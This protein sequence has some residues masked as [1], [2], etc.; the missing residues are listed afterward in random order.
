MPTP[1]AAYWSDALG[2]T[3]GQASLDGPDI[4]LGVNQSLIPGCNFPYGITT[5]SQHIYWCNSGDTG[6][7]ANTIGRANL[8]GTDVNQSFISG[9]VSAHGVAVGQQ[10][11]WTSYS[12]NAIGAAN[13]DGTGANPAFITGI[14][15]NP[16]GLAVDSQYIYW[17]A[18]NGGTI[19][20]ANLD[21]TG[22][23]PAF[24]NLGEPDLV[25]PNGVAVDSQHIF[26]SDGD[27]GI[28]MANLDGTGVTPRVIPIGSVITGTPNQVAVD[29]QGHVYWTFNLGEPGAGGIGV[30]VNPNLVPLT[31]GFPFGIAVPADVPADPCEYLVQ[32]L[33]NLSPSDFP[34]KAEYLRILHE[35]EEQLAACRKA[36]G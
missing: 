30:D 24:I 23:N 25:A 11:Y 28:G 18:V 22:V 20:R 15:G 36:H 16:Y 12:E 2:G 1:P 4:V 31:S 7:A 8:D 19:G 5:D 14:S 34:N 26:W 21:G 32:A 13:L 33:A 9:A 10:V 35:L 29:A 17:T 6:P 3:I 27:A